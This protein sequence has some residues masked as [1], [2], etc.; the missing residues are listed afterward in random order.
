VA[1][2]HESSRDGRVSQKTSENSSISKPLFRFDYRSYGG[3]R[4]VF[5]IGLA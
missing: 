2:Q 3:L 1:V 5:R 4:A